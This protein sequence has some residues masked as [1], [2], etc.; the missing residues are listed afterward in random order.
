MTKYYGVIGNRDHIKYQGQKRPFWE[1]LDRQPDGYLSSLAYLPTP[2]GLPNMPM[3]GDCGAWSYKDHLLEAG[4]LP[5]L[6][7]FDPDLVDLVF[8]GLETCIID[9]ETVESLGLK[10]KKVD[11]T[12]RNVLTNYLLHFSRGDLVI[13]PD[14]MLI[15]GLSDNELNLR[16][17]FNI[18]SAREFLPMATTLGFNPMATVHG[19]DLEERLISVGRLYEIGYRHFS[20]GGMAARA[21]QKKMLLESIEAITNR[22]RE[23]LPDAWIHVLGLS[24]PDYFRAFNE[25][26]I[27]SCDGSS[28][29]KQAFTAGTFFALENGKMVK[30]QAARPTKGEIVSAPFCEC[31]ACSKLREEGIDT[32]S[33]GSNENNMGRAAHNLNMLMKAQE[34]AVKL[35]GMV[36]AAPRVGKSERSL[37][38]VS[39]V[40]KK[41][42][43]PVPARDLYQSSWFLKAKAYVELQGWDWRIISAELGLL[44]P[45]LVTAPYEKT[46]NN[47]PSDERREWAST[48]F[49]SILKEMPDGG[50]IRFFAG[51]RYR[52]YLAPLLEN[53]GYR[54]EIPLKGLGI[55]QQLVWFDNQN[56]KSIQLSLLDEINHSS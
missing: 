50:T 12:P 7:Q 43:S 3:I 27:D 37:T 23:L 14:H 17:T 1:F 2:F 34:I 26:G 31:T 15:P 11:V 13:A 33:Y 40:G 41:H 52:E 46:L 45:E 21:G 54:V 25:M 53:A 48:V 36:I 28:H 5:V 38:L 18:K 39:C 22:I 56:Q 47:M 9:A 19:M 24:S 35:N 55:G 42:P 51:D 49:E 30:H 16:R 29:F 10:T 4:G 32:R 6:K 44:H 8:P 20:L